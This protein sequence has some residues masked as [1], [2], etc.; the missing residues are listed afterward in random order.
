MNENII[1]IMR[2]RIKERGRKGEYIIQRETIFSEL[3]PLN[4][5]I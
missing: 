2:W 1:L 4:F 3:I 5:T